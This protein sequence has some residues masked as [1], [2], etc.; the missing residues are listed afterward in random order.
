MGVTLE[1]YSISGGLT[2][3][4]DA[5]SCA[6]LM[7]ALLEDVH[8]CSMGAG[9]GTPS[10]SMR[11]ISSVCRTNSAQVRGFF[12]RFL[13]MFSSGTMD[14]ALQRSIQKLKRSVPSHHVTLGAIPF[15]K[16]IS[17]LYRTSRSTLQLNVIR[18]AVT[19]KSCVSTIDLLYRTVYCT[20]LYSS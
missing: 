1:L 17:V 2:V 15:R 19:S 5:G 10:S 12:V 7:P 11:R 14:N 8:R 16:H 4:G 3:S 9:A 13:R 20:V 6:G 18:A